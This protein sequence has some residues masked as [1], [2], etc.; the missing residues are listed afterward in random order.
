MAIV[1]FGD[2]YGQ[3]QDKTERI[4]FLQL[5]NSATVSAPVCVYQQ[6]VVIVVK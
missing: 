1:S 4:T 5:C 2:I 3:Y 6:S